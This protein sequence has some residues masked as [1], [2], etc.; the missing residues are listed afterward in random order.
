VEPSHSA[1]V[2]L[3]REKKERELVEVLSK[4]M[5][6]AG[7]CRMLVKVDRVIEFVQVLSGAGVICGP[8]IKPL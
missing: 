2:Q 3:N 4:Q 6:D 5:Q 1:L 8:L 7:A